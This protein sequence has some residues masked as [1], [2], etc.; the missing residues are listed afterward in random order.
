MKTRALTATLRARMNYISDSFSAKPTLKQLK[1]S[2]LKGKTTKNNEAATDL[3]R[4]T[5]YTAAIG[6]LK[7]CT[8]SLDC[9][10]S[11]APVSSP[12]H[13]KAARGVIPVNTREIQIGLL[14]ILRNGLQIGQQ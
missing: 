11:V 4:K 6:H 2:H 9:N 8:D 14:K 1:L 10:R 13:K 5:T 12:E 7:D 3:K